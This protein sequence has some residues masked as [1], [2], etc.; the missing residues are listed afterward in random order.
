MNKNELS[1]I[2]VNACF[3]IYTTL[4]SGLLESVYEQILAY[5]LSKSDLE[6]DKQRPLPVIYEGVKMDLGFR[7]DI[8]VNRKVIIEIKSVE[9]IAPVHHKQLLTHLKLTDIKLGLLINFNENLI[10]DGIKRVV[11]QL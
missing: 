6:I 10:K 1:R 7:P 9:S 11:N 8:I 3:K 2:I 5:E 4:G